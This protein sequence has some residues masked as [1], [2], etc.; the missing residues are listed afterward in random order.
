MAAAEGRQA[1]A[2]GLNRFS[3]ADFIE[4]LAGGEQLVVPVLPA[5]TASN[6]SAIAVIA[7]VRLA[8]RSN[9]APNHERAYSGTARAVPQVDCD[10]VGLEDN[11]DLASAC[12]ASNVWHD[13][14]G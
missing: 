13:P 1:A 7:W 2:G 3:P 8:R 12:G 11:F 5:P 4:V 14:R 9:S 10:L 6:P